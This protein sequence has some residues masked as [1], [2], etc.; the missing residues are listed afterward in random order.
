MISLVHVLKISASTSFY[1]NYSQSYV[2]LI[3]FLSAFLSSYPQ[4]AGLSCLQAMVKGT[5]T[6][7]RWGTTET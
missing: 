3:P 6:A 1:F 7:L 5:R 4:K 2:L